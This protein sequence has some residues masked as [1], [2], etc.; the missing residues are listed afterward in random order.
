M[1]D[2]KNDKSKPEAI[3]DD[4]LDQ[5]TG[6]SMTLRSDGT[7]IEAGGGGGKADLGD[8]TIVK[9]PDDAPTNTLKS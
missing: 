7:T 8:L 2:P 5:V 1:T 3:D 9:Y 4:D 6:G